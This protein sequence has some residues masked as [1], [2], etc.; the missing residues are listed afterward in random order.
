MIDNIAYYIKDNLRIESAIPF[1]EDD[2]FLIHATRKQPYSGKHMYY[3]LCKLIDKYS[4]LNMMA[5][6][7]GPS[8]AYLEKA[9]TIETISSVI[10]KKYDNK[11]AISDL[12]PIITVDCNKYYEVK[13]ICTDCRYKG[14]GITSKFVKYTL[15]KLCN[16]SK[17]EN[18]KACIYTRI[19]ICTSD[20]LDGKEPS[21]DEFKFMLK[22]AMNFYEKCGF[23]QIDGLLLSKYSCNMCF[24]ED[25]LAKAIIKYYRHYAQY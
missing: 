11:N 7:Y 24:I 14:Q 19:N 8:I 23:I 18:N 20:Y 25:E 3:I 9:N 4:S 5:D 10:L 2:I 16:D 6:E 21:D 13:S 12:W 1:I 15:S 22:N 17:N